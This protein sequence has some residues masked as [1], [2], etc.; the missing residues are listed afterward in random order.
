MLPQLAL[1]RLGVM[2]SLTGPCWD[3]V[4]SGGRR[5]SQSLVFSEAHTYMAGL[6]PGQG[7][8]TTRNSMHLQCSE[9][10]RPKA[11]TFGL[12]GPS[13]TESADDLW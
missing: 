12:G 10:V 11:H 9:H 3:L 13:T 2:F 1:S 7:A 6:L 8:L 5:Y 4:G